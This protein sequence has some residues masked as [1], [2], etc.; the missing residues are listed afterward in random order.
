MNDP[1]NLPTNPDELMAWAAR[2]DQAKRLIGLFLGVSREDVDQDVAR[3]LGRAL[4][5]IPAGRSL[6]RERDRRIV[7]AVRCL[8]DEVEPDDRRLREL[9]LRLRDAERRA[10]LA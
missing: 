8:V 6:R 4:R 7:R 10:G 1:T 9:Q 5:R 2:S 3:V